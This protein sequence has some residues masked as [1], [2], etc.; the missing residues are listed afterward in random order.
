MA[1]YNLLDKDHEM[2]TWSCFHPFVTYNV[3]RFENWYC[4][5]DVGH[6]FVTL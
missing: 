6:P 1:L 4:K 2:Y 3:F 5:L